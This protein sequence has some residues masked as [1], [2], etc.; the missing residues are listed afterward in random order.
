MS[1]TLASAGA[2]EILPAKSLMSRFHDMAEHSMCQPGR[3]TVA[4]PQG[5]GQPGSPALEG[6]HSTKSVGSRL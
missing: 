6:F 3:P 4:M 2:Q 5:E 1:K